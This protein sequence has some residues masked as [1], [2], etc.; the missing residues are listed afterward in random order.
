[1]KVLTII[2]L[3]LIESKV[4]MDIEETFVGVVLQHF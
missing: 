1:M 3:L 2:Q 4:K